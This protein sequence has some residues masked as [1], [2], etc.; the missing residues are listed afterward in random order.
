MSFRQTR[1]R[2]GLELQHLC[3]QCRS[4]EQVMRCYRHL[5]SWWWL[6]R[7]RDACADASPRASS[8]KDIAGSHRWTHHGAATDRLEPN[9]I[10]DHHA[11]GIGGRPGEGC[12]APYRNGSRGGG[13]LK[14]Q[15]RQP[16]P[17]DKSHQCRQPEENEPSESS[18]NTPTLPFPGLQPYASGLL[19][20]GRPSYSLVT[21]ASVARS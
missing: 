4:P 15:P 13:A 17:D 16:I 21:N 8:C 10:I 20:L 19:P 14:P 3:C 5:P 2:E 12:R 11:C 18:H 9:L 1:C 7:D 6:D